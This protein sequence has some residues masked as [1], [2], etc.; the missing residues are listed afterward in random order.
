MSFTV[1][2][3]ARIFCLALLFLSSASIV[4]IVTCVTCASGA[5]ITLDVEVGFRGVFQL[6][7]PFPI[8]VE[9]N[10]QGPA[11][12]GTVEATVWQG[13]A[14]KGGGAF[15]VY[16]RRRLFVG[17][18]ARR[19]ASFTIDPGAISRPLLVSFQAL[20]TS[21]VREV[22]LRRH[23]TPAPL[24][25]LVTESGFASVP[26][27]GTANPLISV[28]PEELPS[29]ADAY[30]GVA[31]VVLYEPSLR[32]LSGAQNAAL[33]AWLAAGG[34]IVAL[35]SAHYAPYQEPAL[36][37]FLPV[38]VGGLKNFR[39]LPN[40]QKMYGAPS[41]ALKNVAAQE[42]KLIEGKAVIEE[43]GSPI[44]VEANRGKGKILYLALDLGRPPL[45]LWEGR[46][47]LFRELVASGG[48][49]KGPP[50]PAW[51]DAIFSQ[52]F[53]NRAVTASYVPIGAFFSWTVLYL[54]GLGFLT[55]LWQGR[56]L[57]G[58]GLGLCFL[59][60]V[61]SASSGGYFYLS[62]GGR[63]PDGVLMTSTLLEPVAD[64]YVEASTNAAL[65]STQ[66]REYV[67][68]VEKG[69]T[70]FE[71]LARRSGAPE[72]NALVVEEEGG[73]PRF[74]A[75]W[76]QWDYRLFRVRSITRFP[77]RVE[78]DTEPSER[79]LRVTNGSAQDLTDCWMIVAGRRASLGDIPAGTSRVRSFPLTPAGPEA[80]PVRSDPAGLSDIRFNDPM[81]DMLMRYSY[82]SR[83]QGAARW[84][85]GAALFFGWVRGGPRGVSVEDDR[86]STRDFTLFR[87]VFP[88]SEA[89]E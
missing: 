42:A 68:T 48:E 26:A 37:R 57:G 20:R 51:D 23:F 15:P 61:A 3:A 6:G 73:R 28:A 63:I 4:S 87:A 59:S 44:L 19:S 66:R 77:V 8:R 43:E 31:T 46:T 24:V 58:R 78:L 62:R 40:V 80:P 39:S 41:S 55:W 56:R 50:P 52:L 38:R 16:H 13:S 81:R 30:G 18:G 33:D 71:P 29:V 34:R 1:I 21:A 22:D 83:E 2:K 70:D 11:V 89:E 27:L 12:E 79:L 85:G 17:A 10:N 54:V 47:R 75:L 72:E 35:G 45:S 14:V 9:V 86:V 49:I 64:G 67:L 74:R 76:K 25:L 5:E 82:F 53:L 65:F 60:L 36:S 84:G 7:R 88:L 32:E 69:W